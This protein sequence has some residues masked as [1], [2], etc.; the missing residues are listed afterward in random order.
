MVIALAAL[1]FL[2]GNPIITGCLVA[3]LGLL[4]F[5]G[6]ER[7]VGARH[8]RQ[9][10]TQQIKEKSRDAAQKSDAER[11]AA[12]KPGALDRLRADRTVCPECQS[13]GNGKPLQK[14]AA[15]SNKAN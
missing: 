4:F 3:V 6:H 2:R 12:S 15:P 1:N 8:E 9:R 13:S 14:L 7:S 11:V 5:A 10:L